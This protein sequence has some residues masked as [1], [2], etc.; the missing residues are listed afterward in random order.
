[1]TA[2][3][4]N[5]FTVILGSIIGMLIKK[6]IPE[7]I[8]SAVMTGIGICTVYIGYTGAMCGENVLITIASMIL[9]SIIGTLIDI[10]RKINTIGEKLEQRF[11]K[12]SEEGLIAK[13][14]VTA[15]LLF[16]VGSMTITG[17][18]QAGISGKTDLIITKSMLDLMS[19]MMLSSSLGF[20][21]LLSSVF[22]LVFQGA[23]TLTAE[24]IAP[25][26]TT[27]AIN[28]LNCAGSL[29]TLMLGFNLMGISKI[30]VAN[31]LPAIIIAPIIYNLIPYFNKI[32]QYIF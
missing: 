2:N 24:F 22:V 14:F 29:I 5:M 25:F 27:G 16:C 15:S 28:E 11:S 18:L 8:S 32:L 9:G 30:K 10:D 26:L 19:S 12:N 31:Y 17:A 21:V 4:I 1:M 7:R 6:G 23:L 20:G 13:G 3:F